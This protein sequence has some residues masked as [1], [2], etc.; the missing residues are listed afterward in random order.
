MTLLS[1][2]RRFIAV[3][4]SIGVSVADSF[5]DYSGTIALTAIVFSLA[6]VMVQFSAVCSYSRRFVHGFA[7]TRLHLIEFFTAGLLYLIA[8]L[9]FIE[10]RLPRCSC[11]P[12]M[13]LE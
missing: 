11:W 3:A 1:L 4:S 10:T 2:Q 5:L 9:D 12:R 8:D 6:V 7:E 13:P